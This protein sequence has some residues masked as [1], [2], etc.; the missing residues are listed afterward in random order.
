MGWFSKVLDHEGVPTGTKCSINTVATMMAMA[1]INGDRDKLQGEIR[2]AKRELSSMGDG[3]EV[4]G[5][6]V[7]VKGTWYVKGAL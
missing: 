3:D 5:V 4:L 6:Y 7:N 2:N 1:V